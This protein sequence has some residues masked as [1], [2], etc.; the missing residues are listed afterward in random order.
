MGPAVFLW[1][2]DYWQF[3]KGRKDEKSIDTR[4]KNHFTPHVFVL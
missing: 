4:I 2:E 3:L 1:A